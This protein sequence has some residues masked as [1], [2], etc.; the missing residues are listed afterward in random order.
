M[1]FHVIHR[2]TQI[3]FID[4]RLEFSNTDILFFEKTGQEV[5]IIIFATEFLKKQIA[6]GN[7]QIPKNKFFTVDFNLESTY[8]K[9]GNRSSEISN[10]YLTCLLYTSPSPRDATLSRMPS[11]A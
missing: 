3:K 1:E 9:K 5:P 2:R 4:E 7:T 8:L 6:T 11:S 10:M